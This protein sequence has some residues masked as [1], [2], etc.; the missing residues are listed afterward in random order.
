MK[1]HYTD[2]SNNEILNEMQSMKQE[3]DAIKARMLKD[4]DLLESIEKKYNEANLEL[5]NRLKGE[6][7]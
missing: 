4:Y 1:E 3:Y 2:K 5:V 7:K 6:K